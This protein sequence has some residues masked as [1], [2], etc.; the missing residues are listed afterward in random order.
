MGNMI[1]GSVIK[2]TFLC[3]EGVWGYLIT[4]GTLMCGGQIAEVAWGYTG[5]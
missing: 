3:Y 5:R 4:R 2:L 1:A